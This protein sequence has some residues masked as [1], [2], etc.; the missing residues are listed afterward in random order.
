MAMSVRAINTDLMIGFS[1][2]KLC[3]PDPK[4]K[5]VLLI[6]TFDMIPDQ[7]P[8]L[9]KNLN[10]YG[11]NPWDR[12]DSPKLTDEDYKIMKMDGSLAIGFGSASEACAFGLGIYE[13]ASDSYRPRGADVY[14]RTAD[15]GIFERYANDIYSI[16]VKHH[17]V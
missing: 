10:L 4:V 7:L 3:F 17:D 1:L 2:A 5:G 12:P 14:R 8:E 16:M 15:D 11:S 9:A 13:M 6:S